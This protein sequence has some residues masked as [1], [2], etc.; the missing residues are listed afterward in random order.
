MAKSCLPSL[1]RLANNMH[2]Y[3][4]AL[5]LFGVFFM[6][7]WVPLISENAFAATSVH[8]CVPSGSDVLQGSDFLQSM[9]GV[10]EGASCAG[11]TLYPVLMGIKNY[12]IAMPDDLK[13]QF[14]ALTGSTGDHVKVTDTFITKVGNYATVRDL[15]PHGSSM[16]NIADKNVEKFGILQAGILC[17]VFVV[18]SIAVM[19]GVVN[20]ARPG[21]MPSGW[22]ALS[23]VLLWV[24]VGIDW[25]YIVYPVYESSPTGSGNL[26]QA[27]D[28]VTAD[29]FVTLFTFV[30]LVLAASFHTMDTI[31]RPLLRLAH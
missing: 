8:L 9:I 12:D 31:G 11:G 26:L 20:T 23:I 21:D 18:A 22:N 13:N 7:I 2:Q 6:L 10:R 19:V 30:L 16:R 5:L 24:A 1:Y 3:S 4:L 27:R 25:G 29:G 17:F 15:L 14:V 28:P